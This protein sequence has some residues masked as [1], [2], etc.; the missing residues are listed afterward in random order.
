MDIDLTG[1]GAQNRAAD[2]RKEKQEQ[3]SHGAS[4]E[5]GPVI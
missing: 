1:A 4:G 2:H 5:I 3:G